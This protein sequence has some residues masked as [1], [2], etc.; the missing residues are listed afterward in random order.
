[1]SGYNVLWVPGTD[2]AGIATQTVVEKQLMR[3][4]GKTRHDLGTPTHTHTHTH[5]YIWTHGYTCTHTHT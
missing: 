4:Q 3:E 5:T 1:M 2:H